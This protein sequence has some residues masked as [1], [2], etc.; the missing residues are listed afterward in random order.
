MSLRNV[1]IEY[2]EELLQPLKNHYR[3]L[4]NFGD[5]ESIHGHDISWYEMFARSVYGIIAYT[6]V[7]GNNEYVD[8]YNKYIN[9]IIKDTRYK[10]FTNYDQK[11][12]ELIPLVSMLYIHQ[13]LTWDKYS[14]AQ[15]NNL[16]SY[17]ENINTIAIN[18]NNWLFFRVIV[19]SLLNKLS[20]TD[21]NQY[22]NESW[23]SINKCYTGDGWYR[24]GMDGPKDYYIA[25]GYHFYSLLYIYLFDDK[26]RERQIRDRAK[27]FAKEYWKM[28]DSKGRMIPYG[29]SLI[30]RFATLSFWSLYILTDID[31]SE[32][33]KILSLIEQNLK[34]WKEK[35]I[36]DGEGLLNLGYSYRNE[37]ICENYNSSGSVYW[38]MKFFLILLIDKKNFKWNTEAP[39]IDSHSAIIP[40]A[41]NDIIISS[42]K[43]W[44]CAFINSYNGSPNPQN[45]A[46][47]MHFAYNSETGFNLSK[48]PTN[49]SKLSDDASLI[50]NIC[51]VKHHRER[52]LFYRERNLLQDFTWSCGNLINIRSIVIPRN[53]HFIRLHIIESI[54]ECDC[55][56]TGFAIQENNI[57]RRQ[58]AFQTTIYNKHL[59]SS[60]ACLQGQGDLLTIENEC[61][62]NIYYKHTIM[63]S[64]KYRINKG[65]NVIADITF[66]DTDD[67]KLN[68]I[69][70]ECKSSV[71]KRSKTVTVTI[72]GYHYNI[73]LR[74]S[75]TIKTSILYFNLYTKTA[76]RVF[77]VFNSVKK[78]VKN[79]INHRN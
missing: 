3:E 65:I 23:I 1:I 35:N 77:K 11:A 55:Y 10:T 66:L 79:I 28:F 51:G 40:I 52:N 61:N 38:V 21:Y 44:N 59:Y 25:F 6:T 73:N 71:I 33:A 64:I 58:N 7:K 57:S 36:T 41:N 26:Q 13:S 72:N 27:L 50:F 74:G 68:N 19:C 17:F 22:A 14:E 45:A 32:N 60:M 54:I 56:E 53:S 31:P 15:K 75:I 39:T 62:S 34:W 37:S 24:D 4:G 67:Q 49:F 2:L 47:Y 9:E 20:G 12:V 69:I 63:P 78:I 43:T 48:D 18:T 16:I 29:R 76:K 8:I 30:Y 70:Q 5:V 46:K 42:Y